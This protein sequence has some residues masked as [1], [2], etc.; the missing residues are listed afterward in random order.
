MLRAIY[1]TRVLK[2]FRSAAFAPGFAVVLL[3]ATYVAEAGYAAFWGRWVPL[4]ASIFVVC[5]AIRVLYFY[6]GVLS[7]VDEDATPPVELPS[8]DDRV[9]ARGT[10]GRNR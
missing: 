3:L 1:G 2:Q 6:S 9:E 10:S 4:I 8:I 7:V 5:R